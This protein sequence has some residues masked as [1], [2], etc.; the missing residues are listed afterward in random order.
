MKAVTV[1]LD[2]PKAMESNTFKTL[3][4]HSAQSPEIE[5]S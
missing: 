4:D 3:L 1:I 5:Y 2:R